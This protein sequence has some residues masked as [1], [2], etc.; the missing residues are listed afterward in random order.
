M[1]ISSLYYAISVR[2]AILT[3]IFTQC[4]RSSINQPK[5]IIKNGKT[6]FSSVVVGFL[7]KLTFSIVT[8]PNSERLF[9]LAIYFVHKDITLRYQS[10]EHNMLNDLV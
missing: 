2:S 8:K 9:N 6:D 4:T 5:Q 1:D 3:V 7:L 10:K